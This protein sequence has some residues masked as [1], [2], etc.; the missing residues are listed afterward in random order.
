[1]NEKVK[2]DQYLLGEMDDSERET[3]EDRL[4][5]NDDLFYA[6]AERE[7]EL[8]DAFAK[9]SLDDD[10]AGRLRNSLSSFPGRQQKIANAGALGNYIADVRHE[11]QIRSKSASWYERLGF[12]FKMPAFAAAAVGLLLM[13][14]IGVLIVQNRNLSDQVADA[15]ELEELRRRESELQTTLEAERSVSGD[16]TS[17]LE[18]EREQRAKLENELAEVRKQMANAR[19]PTNDAPIV[20]TIATLVLR[21]G[22][23][24]GGSTPVRRLQIPSDAK[25]VAVKVFLPTDDTGPSSV[26]VQ[27]N[28]QTVVQRAKPIPGAQGTS[29]SF[30]V[31]TDKLIEGLNRITVVDPAGKQ[32]VEYAVIKGNK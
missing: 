28:G 25:R 12:A 4:I 27:L 21:P 23:I 5:S 22:G 8:V 31:P 17:D 3:F 13:G 15:S 9:N 26:N 7:N 10:L 1:M 19:P 14:A 32:I 29:V 18:S 11:F 30:S 16:L 24:R 6:V 2:I 20:P